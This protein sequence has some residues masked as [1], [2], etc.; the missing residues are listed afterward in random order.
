[1]LKAKKKHCSDLLKIDDELLLKPL[2]NN[3]I[4]KAN[5][6]HE[7]KIA[8]GATA[9]S[10]GNTVKCLRDHMTLYKAD[11]KIIDKETKFIA[12]LLNEDETKRFRSQQETTKCKTS[13]KTREH[14]L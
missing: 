12:K 4:C 1:M 13:Q 8:V 14:C 9:R 5:I 6:S 11:I 3:F 7:G 10:N 2:T